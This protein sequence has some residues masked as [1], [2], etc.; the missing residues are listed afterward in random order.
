MG[1]ERNKELLKESGFQNPE[2][3]TASPNDLMVAIQAER[4]ET[5]EEIITNFEKWFQLYRKETFCPGQKSLPEALRV[6]PKANLAVISIPGAYAAKEARQALEHGLHVFLFSSNVSVEEE[7]ALKDYARQQGLLVMGPDCGTSIIGGVGL[8]FANA[9][10]QGSIGVIGASGTGIQEFTALIHQGGLGISQA[11]GVGSRDLSDAIGG[12]SARSALEALMADEKTELITLI[13]KPPG[14]KAITGLLPQIQQSSKPIVICFLGAR[15]DFLPKWPHLYPTSYIDEAAA[16]AFH[17][18]TGQK[19]TRLES[20]SAEFLNLLEKEIALLQPEQ[21]YVRGLFA[22][23]TFC[24][25]AQQIF[26]EAGLRVYSNAP[27]TAPQKL[28]DPLQRDGH[29]FLDLGAEEFTEGRPHPMIDAR[30]RREQILKEAQNSQI[31]VLLL[32]IILGYN[33]SA[34]P[35][36]DLAPAIAAAKKEAKK[37]GRYLSIVA[38]ICGTENDPQ[39]LALQTKTLAQE[40]VV[41]FNSSAQAARFCAQMA[42]RQWGEENHGRKD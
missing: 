32:D 6:K 39:D 27:L 4:E 19:A 2:I 31:A 29:I 22:G 11:I 5:I 13:S 3:K 18:A 9:V 17:V 14:P 38:S 33:S 41:I 15:L 23:G 8:G 21:K 10:R 35:A 24:Y 30:W 25:Q 36:G 20:C 7:F 34:N 16:T 26:K 40:G 37:K 1:T 42:L 12:F 28:T